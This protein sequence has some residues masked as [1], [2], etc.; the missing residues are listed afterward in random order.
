MFNGTPK[1]SEELNRL[2]N[3]KTKKDFIYAGDG[4]YKIKSKVTKE[5]Y[6]ISIRKKKCNC[7]SYLKKAICIHSLAYSNLYDLS[8]FGSKFTGKPKV[9]FTKNK[10]GAKTGGRSRNAELAYKRMD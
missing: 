6:K 3:Q 4:L 10:R 2:A 1:Y 9:F 8:W 5:F 7:K